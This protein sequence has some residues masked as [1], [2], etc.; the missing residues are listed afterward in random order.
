MNE[1][2]NLIVAQKIYEAR[3]NWSAWAA[4]SKVGLK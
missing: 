2:I 3:G 1:D 4:A